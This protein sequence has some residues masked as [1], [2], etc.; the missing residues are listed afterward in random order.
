MARQC[1]CL[2][3]DEN[4]TRW[5]GLGY[6]QD[7]ADYDVGTSWERRSWGPRSR[8]PARRSGHLP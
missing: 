2:G 6:I 4:Y 3:G 7:N 1:G 5:F 8:P